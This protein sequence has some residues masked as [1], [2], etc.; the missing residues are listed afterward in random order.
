MSF[1]CLFHQGLVV[2][3]HMQSHTSRVYSMGQVVPSFY[4]LLHLGAMVG[5]RLVVCCRDR[6]FTPRLQPACAW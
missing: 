3:G 4:F 5:P 2:V 6:G 1:R